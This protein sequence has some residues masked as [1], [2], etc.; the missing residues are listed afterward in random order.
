MPYSCLP[1]GRY[2]NVLHIFTPTDKIQVHKSWNPT[3]PGKC[4]APGPSFTGYA[5]V[6]I[7][8]DIIVTL[9]PIPVLLKLNVSRG[10]KIGLI[11][12]FM[13]GIFITLCSIF[14]YREIDRIQNGDGNSTMLI[15]WGVIEFNVGVRTL[16]AFL[17]LHAICIL[18]ALIL[19]LVYEQMLISL[20]LSEHRLLPAIPCPQRPT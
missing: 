5:I 20:L 18:Q 10:K 19:T 15:L 1:A 6:T 3:V 17:H 4:L 7:V 8:S 12:I 11:F 13:L 2:P 9:I 14:R 16:L